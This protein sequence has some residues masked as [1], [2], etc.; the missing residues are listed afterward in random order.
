M[1]LAVFMC[2]LMLTALTVSWHYVTE[3]RRDCRS[4]QWEI[5]QRQGNAGRKLWLHY[6]NIF[7]SVHCG[8]SSVVRKV[9]ILQKVTG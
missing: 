7:P 9:T 6:S 8:D 3:T 4:A 1:K 2:G 5:D